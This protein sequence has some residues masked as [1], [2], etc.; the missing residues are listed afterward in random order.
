MTRA[1]PPV[2]SVSFFVGI[3]SVVD[4]LSGQLRDSILELSIKPM[5]DERANVKIIAAA[6]NLDGAVYDLFGFLIRRGGGRL[7]PVALS[8]SA[9]GKETEQKYPPRQAVDVLVTLLHKKEF[10]TEADR[11]P[12]HCGDNNSGYEKRGR[13]GPRLSK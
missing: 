13:H 1:P 7:G 5:P 8:S 9:G 2:N 10:I 6:E 4:E 3:D 11:I 12:K